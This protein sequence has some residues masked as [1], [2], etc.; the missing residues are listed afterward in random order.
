MGTLML[1]AFRDAHP[2]ARVRRFAFRAL[3]PAFADAP[4]A[5]GGVAAAEGRAKLWVRAADG[6]EHVAGEVEF[7]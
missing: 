3:S 6:R 5:C 1:D 4:I 7:D 2:R